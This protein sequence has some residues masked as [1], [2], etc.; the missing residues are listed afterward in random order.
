[1]LVSILK[2]GGIDSA[3]L[4][5]WMSW[6]FGKSNVYIKIRMIKSNF[7][8][9]KERQ[10][11]I[12]TVTTVEDLLFLD[13]EGPPMEIDV[14]EFRLD[15]LREHLDLAESVANKLE[16]RV[17]ITARHPDEGGVGDLDES[18]RHE[19]LARF[20][21]KAAMIDLELRSLQDS[22]LLCELANKAQA[23]GVILIGTMHDFEMMP[24]LIDL[25]DA[26]GSALEIG[27]DIVKIAVVV[28]QMVDVFNLAELVEATEMPVSAMGMGPLGKLSRLVLARAGSV[29]NYGYLRV[30]NAPGQWPASELRRLMDEIS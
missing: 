24:A 21:P 14:F 20:V 12:G 28:E 8:N 30:S 11:V 16:G 13:Q 27:V 4:N 29:L 19:L 9:L 3:S 7:Q 18:E 25:H 26:V 10:L 22:Q 6:N 5:A 17:L 1:M 23:A 15:N 2:N